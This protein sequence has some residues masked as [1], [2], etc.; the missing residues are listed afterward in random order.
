[1]ARGL[2]GNPAARLE[3]LY[4]KR[5]IDDAECFPGACVHQSGAERN[6]GR[7]FRGRGKVE[8]STGLCAIS[9]DTLRDRL[10][11]HGLRGESDIDRVVG[12]RISP[13]RSKTL[14]IVAFYLI[15]RNVA[16]TAIVRGDEHKVVVPE[17]QGTPSV[18]ANRDS[19]RN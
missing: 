18:I 11:K 9:D 14:K 8:E 4:P 6:C 17:R 5:H 19:E 13:V 2:P 15:R 7:L 16:V 12:I 1:M 10:L 3:P